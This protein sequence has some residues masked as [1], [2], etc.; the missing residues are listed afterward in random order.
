[1]NKYSIQ[2]VSKGTVFA[3]AA[4]LL[5]MCASSASAQRTRPGTMSERDRNLRDREMQ[6]TLMEKG[7]KGSPKPEPQLL[8]RE[9]NEDFARLQV[10]NNEVKLKTS[11]NAVLDFKY[12][13]NAAA[14]IKKRSTR[15]RTNLVFPES[16]KTE[17]REQ[18]LLTEGLKS[19]LVKL[20][21]LIRN[22][23]TNPVFTDANVINTELA[24]KARGDLD[25]IIE[26]SDKVKKHAANLNKANVNSH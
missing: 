12:V 6:I 8:L 22:F 5:C 17:K 4:A 19:Q 7:A 25:E 20:D 26:L 23:V 24:A 1:M 10:V 16:A 2:R 11:A 3:M 14:E 13:S 21:R 15:L 9:I 18:T